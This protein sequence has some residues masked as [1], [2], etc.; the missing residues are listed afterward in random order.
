MRIGAVDWNHRGW[1]GGFYPETMPQEW[2]LTYYSNEFD[3]VLVPAARWRGADGRQWCADTPAEFR[4]YLELPSPAAVEPLLE[5]G[6]HLGARFGGIVARHGA[7]AALPAPR[8]ATV[9]R[10]APQPGAGDG[11]C[12]RPGDGTRNCLLG[13]LDC[14]VVPDRRTLS[15]QIQAF[16]AQ[17]DV[18]QGA[19]LLLDGAPPAI[20]LLQDALL[21]AGL[22][23]L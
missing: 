10:D 2:W 15:T 16:A 23:G 21:I 8:R 17:T 5:L 11:C 9:Y 1:V 18:S 14:A 12:W 7:E 3:S 6:D 19:V 13:I 22:L 4:F 20:G